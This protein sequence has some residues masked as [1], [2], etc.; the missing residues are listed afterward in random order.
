MARPVT[1]LT[2][3]FVALNLFAGMMLSSG[4]AADLGISPD[5][6]GDE[7]VDEAVQNQQD[8]TTGTTTGS[9]LFGMYNVLSNQIGSLFSIL[10]PGLLMLERAGVPNYIT[11]GF[12][13]PLF[14]VMIGITVMS[15]LRGW[16]L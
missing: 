12:F 3:F 6:G 13:G 1:T 9:T 4:A 11:Q 7:A 14:S 10:F 5:V 2:I 15:F 16:G 8:V